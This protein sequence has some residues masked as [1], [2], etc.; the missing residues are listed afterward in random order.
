MKKILVKCTLYV[1]IEVPE[2]KDYNENFDIEEN[3]CPGT[4]IVGA[5]IDELITW[6][7]ENGFCWACKVKGKCEI[8]ES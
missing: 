6:G 3:H 1:P 5:A 7:E 8:I 2:D 4:G